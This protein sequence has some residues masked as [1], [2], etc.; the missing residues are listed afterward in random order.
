MVKAIPS[1]Q[2]SCN[3]EKN[4]IAN[5]NSSKFSIVRQNDLILVKTDFR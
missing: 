5:I 2:L 3:L 1:Q 4:L